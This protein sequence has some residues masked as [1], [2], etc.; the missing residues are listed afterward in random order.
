MPRLSATKGAELEAFWRAHLDGWRRSE[1]NQREYCEAHGLPLKRFGN[2]RAKLRH[3]ITGRAGKLL[4]RRGGGLRHMAS[5]MPKEI[6]PAPASYIPSGRSSSPVAR[7]NFGEAD[8]R[9]IVAEASREG[10]SV[11]GVAK[12]YGIGPR[13]LFRWKQELAPQAGA[14]L[15]PVT[16]ADGPAGGTVSCLP[17]PAPV[18]IERPAPGIEVE[19][20]GGRRVRFERD[21]D[22]ETVRRLVMLLE[23]SDS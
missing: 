14:T 3:E 15:L 17:E 6:V 4:Y 20:V 18:I 10:A 11:S 21:A 9:R 19:L 16:I 8:K 1:L 2:W 23:G 12:K 5:H 22:P 13:L 7:R